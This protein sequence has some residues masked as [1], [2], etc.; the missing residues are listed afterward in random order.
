MSLKRDVY[1]RSYQAGELESSQ[2]VITQ[3]IEKDQVNERVWLHLDRAMTHFVEGD[4]HLA[5]GDFQIALETIDYYNRKS[6]IETFGQTFFCDEAAPYRGDDFEQLLVRI[7][8]ALACLHEGDESNAYA[9]LRQAEEWIE[10]KR[11][12]YASHHLT[13]HFSLRNNPLAPYLF[14]VL[15]EK[16]GDLSNA[17][18]LYEK[19]GITLDQSISAENSATVLIFCHNGNVPFKASRVVEG[20]Q[21]SMIALEFLL[22]NPHERAFCSFAGVPAPELYRWPCSDPLITRCSLNDINRPLLTIYNVEEAKYLELQEQRPLVIARGVARLAI[23]RAA[24]HAVQRHDQ[25]CAPVVDIG[26]LVLNAMTRADTRSWNLLPRE[27]EMTRYDVPPGIHSLN[28]TVQLPDK[29]CGTFASRLSLK[30]HDLCI[31]HIFNI[32]PGVTRVL[33]P[34]RFQETQ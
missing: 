3:L 13:H 14:A 33:I 7:Y 19:S 25:N 22:A 11:N 9:L 4:A 20:S 16:Q 5:K 34:Q 18:I 12:E 1:V 28:C 24:L 29:T 8:F 10:T 17:K 23:R 21:A 31:I 6:L 32:H 26:M 2:I 30:P 15:L 27:I